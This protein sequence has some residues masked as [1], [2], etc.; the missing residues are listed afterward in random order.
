MKSILVTGSAG[1]IGSALSLKL[2][3]QGHDVVGIDNMCDYYD[4][5]LKKARLNRHI[6]HVN[7]KHYEIDIENQ[8]SIKNVFKENNF[9]AVINLAAQAGVR[10]SIKN[11]HK[12]VETNVLGF[13][14]ILDECKNMKIKHLVYASSSSVYGL[15]KNTPFSTNKM[16]NH[17]VSVYAATKK[18]NE[19]LAHSYSHLYDLP[20]TGLRFF[21]VYGPWDRP[22]MALQLF[23]NSI[24]N[25]KPIKL[26]NYGKH[27]RDFTYIDDIVEGISKVIFKPAEINND[28]DPIDPVAS[29]SSAP[30]RIYNIGN[31]AMVELEKYV[32]IL[33]KEL[34]K[35]TKR[36]LLPMQ[37]GDVE[38]TLADVNELIDDFDYCPNT[39]IEY[40]IKEFVS[41]YKSYYL[42]KDLI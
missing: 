38:D 20:T 1:F 28:W 2:L 18:S 31:N 41:W 4:I 25:N 32:S 5:D 15:N 40:G 9:D 10:Y 34:G 30:Y 23:A 37:S 16:T 13:L 14:N 39:S 21:T 17:P 12:Y 29:S 7:Y 19:L 26:F 42:N 35:K 11:P 22:D 8:S 27:K 6:N 36:E 33:E 24:I 3:D